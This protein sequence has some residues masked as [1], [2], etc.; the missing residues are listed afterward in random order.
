MRYVKSRYNLQISEFNDGVLVFNSL[1]A[2]ILWVPYEYWKCDEYI[3]EIT[4][5][6]EELIASGI[7]IADDRNEFTELES[8]LKNSIKSGSSQL[9]VTIVP[10]YACNMRCDYCF[11]KDDGERFMQRDMADAI[12]NSIVSIMKNHKSLHITWFGGEPL[13]ALNIMKYL[14]VKFITFCTANCIEYTSDM[15]TNGTLLVPEILNSLKEFEIQ[16]IQVTLDGTTHDSIRKMKDGSSSYEIIKN[17]IVSAANCFSIVVRSNVTEN[18][19]CSIKDMIDDLMINCNLANRISF[20]F[21]PVSEFKGKDSKNCRYTQFCKRNIYA[22]KLME[23]IKHV[24]KYQSAFSVSNMNFYHRLSL[25]K[26]YLKTLFVS[27]HMVMYTSVFCRCRT[28]K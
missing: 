22:S 17:N 6:W 19:V 2:S 28:T 7:W 1:T 27:M 21:Y 4:D 26:R 23:L 16:R 13:L 5:N 8:Y 18:N 20:S 3:G 10:T 24:A 15:I 9:N 25:V 11:Q 14:S 12:F